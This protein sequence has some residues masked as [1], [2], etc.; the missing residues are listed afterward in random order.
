MEF[1]ER[2]RDL[3]QPSCGNDRLCAANKIEQLT[4]ELAVLKKM[5]VVAAEGGNCVPPFL[6]HSNSGGK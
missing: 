2:L 3:S 4:K 6:Y 1:I 5:V